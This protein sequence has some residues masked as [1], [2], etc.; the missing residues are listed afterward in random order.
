MGIKKRYVMGCQD[1]KHYYKQLKLGNGEVMRWIME[2]GFQ[3]SE[4]AMACLLSLQKKAENR[5]Q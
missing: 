2:Q 5:L 4:A 3:W 1:W